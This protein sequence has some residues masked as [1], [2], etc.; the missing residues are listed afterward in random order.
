[1]NGLMRSIFYETL[2]S[3]KISVLLLLIIGAVLLATGNE[4]LLLAFSVV[5]PPVWSAL[6]FSSLRKEDM[7]RW[8]KYKLTFPV[9]RQEIVQSQYI[10]HVAGSLFGVLVSTVFM[11]G[12]HSWQPVFLLWIPRCGHFDCRRRHDRFDDGSDFLSSLLSVGIGTGGAHFG[13]GHS[14]L[15]RGYPRIDRARQL[16]IGW[17]CYRCRILY[18]FDRGYGDNLRD[19]WH[20]L[21]FVH[22]AVSEKRVL[23]YI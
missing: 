7:S 16:L 10:A 6:M 14:W 15:G 3:I 11:G 2:D 22:K 5:V 8:G 12:T 20:F 4:S 23:G 13:R 19:V 17:A 18:E 1:M 21:Y 9:K